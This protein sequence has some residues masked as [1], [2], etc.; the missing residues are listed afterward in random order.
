[1]H[2][3]DCLGVA[4]DC[5]KPVCV[6]GQCGTENAAK[7]NA[8]VGEAKAHVCDGK[9]NCVECNHEQDC[10]GVASDCAKPV[11]VAGQCGTENAAK[12]NACVDEAKAHVCDG[13]G[14]C[15]ECNDGSDCAPQICDQGQCVPPE[16][17]SD[18]TDCDADGWKV[19]DGDCCDQP[20][21]CG[22]EPKLIN[23]GAIDV[24]GNGIDDNCNGV[25]DLFDVSDTVPCDDGLA[26]NSTNAVDYAKAI[27]I[28][29]QTQE[30]PPNPK[31]KT[32]GLISAALVRADGT[33]LGDHKSHSIRTGFGKTKPAVLEGKSVAVF[34]SGIASDASQQ[35]PGPNGG[36]P[37]GGNV[38]N[39]H[40]P[41]SEVNVLSCNDPSCIKDWFSSE[42]PGLKKKNELPVAPNC[43]AGNAG[44]PELARD[45]VML[46]LRL[47]A[48]TNAKAFSFNS[49]FISAEYPEYVCTNY[50]DQFIALVATPGGMPSPIPNPPDKNLMIYDDGQKKWPVGI[51]IASGT[52]LFAVCVPQNIAGNC[53]DND[54]STKSCALGNSQLTGTGFDKPQG[55]N[56][57][58]GG[59]SYWLTTSGNVIPGDIVE[60]RIVIWD[61][62]DTTFDSLA[63]VDGFKW[64]SAATVPGTE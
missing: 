20:G 24:V 49:F 12:G 14:N 57:D 43:G 22:L 11:C 28:C 7:G 29:R 5:A 36:A 46:K 60:L 54:V 21:P 40:S 33:A 59:G 26:S 37:D 16:C 30:K 31:S 35:N 41:A 9:G 62:G 39:T 55:A 34:S 4:S 23:P 56:C 45:S 58:I 27:G 6:A 15:V 38:S 2:E 64:L 10:L 42:S 13:K 8:C 25:I 44:N 53:W 17:D 63:L 52:N 61:V 3:Q 47:R 1:N 51:N 48:P 50:T 19:A 18:A 32:W